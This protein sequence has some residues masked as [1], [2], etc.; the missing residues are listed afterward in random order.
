MGYVLLMAVNESAVLTAIASEEERSWDW[1]FSI[2][3]RPLPICASCYELA[4]R[5]VYRLI[6]AIS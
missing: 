4:R 2:C 5:G 6:R 3:S 1:S